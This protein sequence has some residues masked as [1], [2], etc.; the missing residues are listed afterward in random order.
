MGIYLVYTYLTRCVSNRTVL[1]LSP[2]IHTTLAIVVLISTLHWP[3]PTQ[4]AYGLYVP[5]SSSNVL[6]VPWTQSRGATTV[7]PT[8]LLWTWCS[9]VPLRIC[10]F[11]P[12][13][14]WRPMELG[15]CT[16]PLLSLPSMLAELRTSLDGC[17]SLGVSPCFLD[18]NTTSTI[19]HKYAPRQKQAFEYGCA[20]GS[21]QGSR[22]GSHVYEINNWLWNFGSPQPR[23]GGLSVAKTERIRRQSRSETARRTAATKKARKRAVDEIWQTYTWYLPVICTN[24]VNRAF[25][26]FM[27]C[28]PPWQLYVHAGAKLW[29]QFCILF[30]CIY[31][32]KTKTRTNVVY[33][34]CI[35]SKCLS[36]TIYIFNSI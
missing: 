14:P 7:T 33:T 32:L 10:T 3:F 5:S 19:P 13:T 16:S 34:R 23:I 21:G 31:S 30:L 12:L 1:Q 2:P 6:C 27:T 36:Y 11:K 24:S 28:L 17:H 29:W 15:S 4:T 8:K 9:L 18:R 26:G 25:R 22:R 20:D 35:L